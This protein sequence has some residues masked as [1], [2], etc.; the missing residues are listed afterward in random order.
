MRTL[1]LLVVLFIALAF[2]SNSLGK[3]KNG[4]DLTGALVP[5]REIFSGGPPRDGI[6]AI[7]Q[8]RFELASEADWLRDED[9]VLALVVDG[10]AKAYP[11]GILNWHEI[12]NDKVGEQDFVVTY[13]PLCGTGVVFAANIADT[14]LQFGVS[15][16]LYNSDVLLYDRNSESLWSQLLGKSISGKLKGVKLPQ[17][18]AAYTTWK[19]WQQTHPD[20]LVLSRNTGFNR[21]YRKSP[22]SGYENSRKLYF[23]VSNKAPTDYHPKERVIGLAI[24]GSFKAYPYSELSKN[25]KAGFTDTVAGQKVKIRWNEDA[26][27]GGVAKENGEALP[28][29]SSF[30]FAWFTFHPDTDVFSAN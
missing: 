9:R 21:D 25:E 27:S 30:W 20:T 19:D 18:P 29:I 12:V 6:P 8:P 3:T 24:D 16:L 10:Q 26:Q 7:N 4:F 2:T 15:G 14:A 5:V 17:L 28:V 13:C 23:K 11:I 22:Y 1:N